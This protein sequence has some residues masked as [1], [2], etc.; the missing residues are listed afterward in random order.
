MPR[1]GDPWEHKDLVSGYEAWKNCGICGLSGTGGIREK[2][3]SLKRLK[4]F[5]LNDDKNGGLARLLYEEN[6]L[7]DTPV[8]RINYGRVDHHPLPLLFASRSSVNIHSLFSHPKGRPWTPD[9]FENYFDSSRGLSVAGYYH[10]RDSIG[11]NERIPDA[12]MKWGWLNALQRNHSDSLKELLVSGLELSELKLRRIG[13]ALP[14]L[15]KL[16]VYLEEPILMADLAF[17][18]TVFPALKIICNE[19]IPLTGL[20]DL[21]PRVQKQ[22]LNALIN[23]KLPEKLK[24]IDICSRKYTIERDTVEARQSEVAAEATL[25]SS[26]EERLREYGV[27]VSELLHSSRYPTLED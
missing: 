12:E 20:G 21:T 24:L 25:L 3:I 8:K 4:T 10:P 2:W 19:T 16:T 17:D 7:K 22:V 14:N 13:L 6:M 11:R 26:L 9:E 23:N 18:K 1:S 15:E 27:R 5:S